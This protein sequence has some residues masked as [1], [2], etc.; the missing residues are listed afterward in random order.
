MLQQQ[1]PS[2]DSA[3][4]PIGN[5]VLFRKAV[6][7]PTFATSRSTSLPPG[8]RSVDGMRMFD[9][10]RSYSRTGAP[11]SSCSACANCSSFATCPCG[12]QQYSRGNGSCAHLTANGSL[13][14]RLRVHEQQDHA[15]RGDTCC[16]TST[17]WRINASN[18]TSSSSSC[19]YCSRGDAVP[20]LRVVSPRRTSLLLQSSGTSFAVPHMP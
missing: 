12:E 14:L 10:V 18:S 11:C 19:S 3:N 4:E 5:R 17:A 16:Q 7:Y 1:L 15:C 9:S 2:N 6:Y 13:A 20:E 8:S